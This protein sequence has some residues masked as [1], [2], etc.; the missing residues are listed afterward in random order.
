VILRPDGAPA[1][2][3]SASLSREDVRR[4]TEFEEFCRRR[5]IS[6][7]LYCERCANEHGPRGARMWANN[8][9]DSAV[10]SMQCQCTIHTYGR[11]SAP[12]APPSA[13]TP[14]PTVIV[15]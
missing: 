5:G 12:V 14:R 7:D 9:R 4:I 13:Y 1:K 11:S 10:F 6:L 8:S 3:K 15:P 2:K